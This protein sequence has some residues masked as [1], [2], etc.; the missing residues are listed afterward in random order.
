MAIILG[1]SQYE[2]GQCLVFSNDG[3]SQQWIIHGLNTLI[4]LFELI[5]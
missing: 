3:Y 5:Y 2:D 4:S 1:L